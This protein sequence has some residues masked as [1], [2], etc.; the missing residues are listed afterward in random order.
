MKK[1]ILCR[2]GV[3]HWKTRC[4]IW[5]DFGKIFYEKFCTRLGCDARRQLTDPL[6]R[7]SADAINQENLRR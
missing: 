6:D 5:G 7:P 4:R 1:P 2:I 3:H